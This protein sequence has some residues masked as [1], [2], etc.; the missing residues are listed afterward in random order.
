MCTFVFGFAFCIIQEVFCIHTLEAIN[1][2]I[3]N[4]SNASV[5]SVL[6][7]INA[8]NYNQ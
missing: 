4:N 1:K 7:F 2:A 6:F 3:G 8:L 5:S